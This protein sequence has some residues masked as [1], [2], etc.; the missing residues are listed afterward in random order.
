MKTHDGFT[1][2][3]TANQH[4]ASALNIAVKTH[5]NSPTERGHSVEKSLGCKLSTASVQ[6]ITI[7]LYYNKTHRINITRTHSLLPRTEACPGFFV[8][9]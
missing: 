1:L 3:Q 5:F 9:V 4:S 8:V 6:N 2:I 7:P